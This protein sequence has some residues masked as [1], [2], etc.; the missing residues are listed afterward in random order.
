MKLR[1]AGENE[2]EAVRAFYWDVIDLMSDRTDTVGWKKGIYPS[3]GLL[4]TAVCRG[5]L[6][7][8]DSEDGYS[9]AVIVNG[10][11]NEGY[12]GIEWG[13][14]CSENEI[15]IPHALAVHP[16]FQRRGIGKEVVR[17]ILG[18]A[19][20][21]GKRTVR[22]DIL[23]GNTAAVRLYEASGFHFVAKK[24]MFYEDTGLTEFLLYEIIL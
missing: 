1:K 15:L 17:D 5:E 23:G 19:R 7:V 24:Q 20:A 10:S 22:L 12:E 11:C 16:R 2:F 6:Y 13:I 3:D 18:I 21:S 8:A 4:R 14:D 9:A